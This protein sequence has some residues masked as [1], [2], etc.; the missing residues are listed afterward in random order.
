MESEGSLPCTQGPAIAPYLQPDEFSPYL[1]CMLIQ[2][3][4]TKQ[5]SNL[6]PIANW[7]FRCNMSQILK[8]ATARSMHCPILHFRHSAKLKV[9]FC[10]KD[11]TRDAVCV[12]SC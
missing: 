11:I 7:C 9:G 6:T 8:D 3:S 5:T 1:H 10:Q 4:N 2:K 12:K